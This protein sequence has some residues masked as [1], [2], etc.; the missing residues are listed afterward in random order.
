MLPTNFMNQHS[1]QEAYYKAFRNVD[2]KIWVYPKDGSEKF[3]KPTS[4]CTAENDFQSAALEHAQANVVESSGIKALRSLLCSRGLSESEYT[5]VSQWIALHMLRNQRMRNAP[6]GLVKDYEH[7]FPAEFEKE[8]LFLQSH[9]KFVHV[10]TSTTSSCFIT[11]DDPLLE[12]QCG[13]DMVLFLTITPQKLVRLSPRIETLKCEEACFEDFVNAMIW[14]KAFKYAFSHS[15]DVDVKKLEAIAEKWNM[16]PRW[17]TQKV[18]I[19]GL[20]GGLP[21]RFQVQS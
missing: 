12:F 4:W 5:F 8:L 15:D 18:V 10:Y 21:S 17:E 6:S 13:E 1:I 7:G 20:L 3:S 11:S 14:S 19:K 2:D 9:Y 16:K